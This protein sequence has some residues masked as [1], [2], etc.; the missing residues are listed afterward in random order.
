VAVALKTIYF[1][2]Q[3]AS[4]AIYFVSQIGQ[5]ISGTPFFN[6]HLL[7][8]KSQILAARRTQLAGLLFGRELVLA[9]VN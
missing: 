8:L 6:A 9:M 3:W 5:G 7:E 4:T 1:P 2:I